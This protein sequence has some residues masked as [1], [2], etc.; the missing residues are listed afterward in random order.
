[1]VLLECGSL[2]DEHGKSW[3]AQYFC[4]CTLS[5]SVN[6]YFQHQQLPNKRDR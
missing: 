4:V 3:Q 5:G 6:N 2:L 1:M